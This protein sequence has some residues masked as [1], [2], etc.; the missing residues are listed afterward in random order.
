MKNKNAEEKYQMLCRAY[1]YKDDR[2]MYFINEQLN[3]QDQKIVLD[4]Q[5]TI[6]DDF[7]ASYD[8]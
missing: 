6:T 3:E 5:H 1:V 7:G 2:K 8:L 4:I